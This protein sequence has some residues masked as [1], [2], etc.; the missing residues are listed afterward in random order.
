M[1]LLTTR[2]VR[3]SVRESDPPDPSAAISSCS[4][5]SA[6]V[7]EFLCRGLVLLEL[8]NLQFAFRGRQAVGFP[9]PWP[10]PL[11]PL[12]PWP[13]DPFRPFDL[14]LPFVC[15]R[16]IVA[17]AMILIPVGL[18]DSVSFTLRTDTMITMLSSVS[19]TLLSFPE[20]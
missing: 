16:S 6:V 7:V 9:V 2:Q 18:S 4:S 15:T 20:K 11:W 19:I 17:V 3:P 14:P 13:F 1:K 5:R 12:L 10:F 8:L